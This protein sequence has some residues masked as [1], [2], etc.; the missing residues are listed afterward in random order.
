MPL[1]QRLKEAFATL[2]IKSS[3]GCSCDDVARKL[4]TQPLQWSR[5]NADWIIDQ[6]RQN[7]RAKRLPF[8]ETI[9]RAILTRAI[10]EEQALQD[11]LAADQAK[12]FVERIEDVITDVRRGP[13]ER[14]ASWSFRPDVV[15]AHKR[16]FA[17]GLASIMAAPTPS[18][19]GSGDGIVTL[20]GGVRY[21]PAAYVLV[22]LL[23]ELG[24]LLPIEC[25]YLSRHEFD[26]AM[27]AALEPFGVRCINAQ[28][29]LP[30]T[31]RA[32][33]GW[34]AKAW[35]MRHSAFRRVLYLDAD[36]V[37]ARDP[38]YLFGELDAV[39][40][41]PDFPN[42]LGL[43]CHRVAWEVLGLP[44]PGRSRDVPGH[45]KP[46]DYTPW[47]S[48][49]L[50]V[51]KS[52]AWRFLDAAKLLSDH[53]DWWYPQEGDR[54]TWPVYGDKSTLLLAAQA[55]GAPVRMA[56]PAELF[57]GR[58]GGGFNQHD[59][60]GQIV[61]QHRCQPQHKIRLSGENS[62]AGLIQAERFREAIE[63]L[64]RTWK[65][66]IWEWDASNEHDL[67]AARANIGPF[68]VTG[69]QLAESRVELLDRGQISG[70]R[71]YH[72]RI[73]HHERR[74]L[75]IVA[76]GQRAAAICERY[77]NGWID[78]RT[79]VALQ[80]TA[81]TWWDGCDSLFSAH[82][83][84]DVV[85]K[86]EYRLPIRMDGQV[87]VDIGAHE[88]MFAHACFERGAATVVSVEPHPE[89][90][91]RLT[92]NLSHRPGSVRLNQ[93]VWGASGPRWISLEA[94][95]DTLPHSGGYQVAA[96]G[97]DPVRTIALDTLL[98]DAIEVGGTERI[99]LLKLDCEGA[100]WP[101]LL[102]AQRLDLV[103]AICGELH[104]AHLWRLP[105][106][107]GVP[108]TRDEAERRLRAVLCAAGLCQIEIEWFA[109]A[110]TLG[111][112]WASR[113]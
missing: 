79:G 28:D 6:M 1:G 64:R 84:A 78:R 12:V 15:A 36:Q 53:S 94:P 68:F 50:L 88:G 11:Q 110:G 92:R 25:W 105:E 51:D 56:P 103:D 113:E 85:R 86:N 87:V 47:E 65:P 19:L 55:T 24:C 48:G 95:P 34:Q 29:A 5:D 27:E 62:T 35:A 21:F 111:H 106:W 40:A 58:T 63:A 97:R 72:W 2:G 71:R 17:E 69:L 96:M 107:W 43:D 102:T 82:V 32:F 44:V 20:A 16:I 77:D 93:A 54:K 33:G 9:A 46:T 76:D 73:I 70:D 13:R 22:R 4:D 101:A 81:P 30:A 100:E 49:Q 104:A 90:F 112:V 108:R 60:A 3:R 7:A 98:L 26:H 57:G 45:D 39:T 31:P 42:H 52:K 41:W 61:F 66:G 109:D 10:A 23:R 83:W 67:A 74:P 8:V 91:A 59:Q 14:E 18:D 75:L 37:P 38:A 99:D 89:N 80:H